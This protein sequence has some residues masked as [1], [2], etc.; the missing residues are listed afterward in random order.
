MVWMQLWPVHDVKKVD[1]QHS[2]AVD[3]SD[4]RYQDTRVSADTIA[5]TPIRIRYYSI[6]H[7]YYGTPP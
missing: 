5:D 2:L 1:V 6:L 4:T 3:T 7:H